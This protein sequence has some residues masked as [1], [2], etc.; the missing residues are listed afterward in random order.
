MSSLR[1]LQKNVDNE[2]LNSTNVK[3]I[4]VAAEDVTIAARISE[5]AAEENDPAEHERRRNAI[6]N[7]RLDLIQGQQCVRDF[8]LCLQ[9]NLTNWP[10][11]FSCFA[12]RIAHSTTCFGCNHTHV[13]ET[14]QMY[15]EVDV[16]PDSCEL[17]KSIDD[18]L[19][20]SSLVDMR[21]DSICQRMVQ[22]EK[23]KLPKI[24]KKGP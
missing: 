2:S 22:K 5:V 7:V 9:E 17:S 18:Y 20:T 21:C 6:L 11:V 23:N 8:F 4:L 19:N 10:D 14:T 16:P 15:I 1:K 12:F 3:H 24:P 13:Y